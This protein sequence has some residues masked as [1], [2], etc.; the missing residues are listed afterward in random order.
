MRQI[1]NHF[2]LWYILFE[3]V[4]AYHNVGLSVGPSY[5]SF[6]LC[7]NFHQSAKVLLMFVMVMG[8]N[9]MLPTMDSECIDFSY[10][11]FRRKADLSIH[12][13]LVKKGDND[14][15]GETEAPRFGRGQVQESTV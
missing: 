13:P 1:P 4:S 9:R 14:A 2:N 5:Q 11:D 7:G 10:A 15:G 6:S 3:V 12:Q 8:K